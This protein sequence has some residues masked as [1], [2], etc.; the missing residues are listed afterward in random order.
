MRVFLAVL[1]CLL[2]SSAHSKCTI[3][4]VTISGKVTDQAG[5][6]VADANVAVSWA[7]RGLPQGP[8]QARSNSDGTFLVAFQFNTFTRHSF[9]RGDVC[10]EVLTHVSASAFAP[11][12]RS[13]YK[14]IPVANGLGSV[15]LRLDEAPG[16]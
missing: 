12:H 15:D 5:M 9:L 10:R 11:G 3:P 7:I 4:V 13:E 6:G 1:M 8:A 14:R 2:A 16:E